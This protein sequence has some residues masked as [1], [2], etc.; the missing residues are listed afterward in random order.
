MSHI[1]CFALLGIL[2][3]IAGCE[4]PAPTLA[5]YMTEGAPPPAS[6]AFEPAHR[7]VQSPPVAPGDVADAEHIYV[8]FDEVSVHQTEGEGEGWVLVSAAVATLDL[9]ALG[10]GASESLGLGELP[11]GW[12]NELRLHIVDSAIVF[13]GVSYPLTI[14][15]G[16]SSGVK[17]KSDFELAEGIETELLLRFDATASISW[18]SGQGYKMSPVIDLLQA[19]YS[20][21]YVPEPP[22]EATPTPFPAPTPTGDFDPG[23]GEPVDGPT[24]T[25]TGGP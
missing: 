17:V 16:E 15:S 4:A 10:E 8:T 22:P 12:Y 3:V 9:A 24:P 6:R 14:P 23:D 20:D 18:S 5:V 25:P 2:G 13:D 7:G 19:S 11:P 1:K 21:G